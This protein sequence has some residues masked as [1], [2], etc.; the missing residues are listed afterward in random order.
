MILFALQKHHS[1]LI[2]I[3]QKHDLEGTSKGR[4]TSKVVVKANQSRDDNFWTVMI[5]RGRYV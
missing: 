3:N 1:E 5:Q 2:R 4:D